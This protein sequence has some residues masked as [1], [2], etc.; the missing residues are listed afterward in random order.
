MFGGHSQCLYML[1]FCA[2][3]CKKSHIAVHGLKSDGHLPVDRHC[4]R[5]STSAVT[6]TT[7]NS[8][9][10][11][12]KLATIRT[13][14]SWHAARAAQRIHQTWWHR[15]SHR[16]PYGRPLAMSPL[17]LVSGFVYSFEIDHEFFLILR[18][19][20]SQG[21]PNL[22]HNTKLGSRLGEYRLN[23][24]GENVP[25][26]SRGVSSTKE[27][28]SVLIVFLLLPFL[29]LAAISWPRWESNYP[30]RASSVRFLISG[31]RIP[32]LPVRGLPG[33]RALRAFWKSNSLSSFAMSVSF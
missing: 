12:S 19:N 16:G 5:T 8:N 4:A 28:L 9:S 33:W 20:V 18:T 21:V 1:G 25:A 23:G 2:I 7:R 17:I 22:M 6:S 24:L 10:I 14:E 32:S 30:S 13:A 27:P 31:V 26:R 29:R 15:A 11:P 3:L